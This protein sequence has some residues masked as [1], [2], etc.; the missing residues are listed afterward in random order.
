MGVL[1]GC[2][3]RVFGNTHL[4]FSWMCVNPVRC[5]NRSRFF[6]G[7]KDDKGKL[8]YA[9]CFKNSKN[10]YR[11]NYAILII[12][13]KLQLVYVILILLSYNIC[14]SKYRICLRKYL[15]FNEPCHRHAVFTLPK[16]LVAYPGMC[17]K[18]RLCGV[19][20]LYSIIL[21]FNSYYLL[22]S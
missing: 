8:T 6:R 11:K 13:S 22:N 5:Y 12:L 3:S 18:M 17:L 19:V 21:C 9:S 7:S 14:V 2:P 1:E 16:H 10:T 4:C 15:S 20:C